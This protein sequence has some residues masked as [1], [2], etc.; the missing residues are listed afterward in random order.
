MAA[1]T[2]II[3]WCLKRSI[4]YYRLRNFHRSRHMFVNTENFKNTIP[5]IETLSV[6]G[7]V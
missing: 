2:N 4:M 7:E 6:R 3:I 1:L 5:G